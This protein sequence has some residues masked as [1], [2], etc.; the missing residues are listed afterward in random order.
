MQELRFIKNDG[1]YLVVENANGESFRLA[2]DE[3]VRNSL[4]PQ[5]QKSASPITISPREI[6]MAVRSGT[7]IAELA[8]QS[9]A[10][11]DFI[12]KFAAPVLDE[13]AHMVQLA[14]SVRITVAGDRYSDTLQVEFGDLISDRLRDAGVTEFA[15]SSRKPETGEWLISCSFQDSTAVWSFD[16]RKLSLSPENE[17][18]VQL[19]NQ[20]GFDSPVPKIKQLT[21]PAKLPAAFAK[22]DSATA[23]LGD[24]ME[25][26]GVIQFGR[27]KQ[28]EPVE[29]MMGEN[30]ANTADLLDALRKKR[31]EREAVEATRELAAVEEPSEAEASQAEPEPEPIAAPEA[32]P[33]PAKKGRAA[34]PSW[35]DIVF[36]TKT[37]SED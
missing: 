35:N 21:P 1:D 19:S 16:P 8:K 20:S 5:T 37:D 36:G 11:S 29:P 30:L 10:S 24:T 6:Q 26:D 3:A 4:K 17:V 15:W 12:E 28:T 23:D 31:L 32:D 27:T 22:P 9:G 18:A 7:G 2:I 34:V 33:K 25:F 14:R 13:L